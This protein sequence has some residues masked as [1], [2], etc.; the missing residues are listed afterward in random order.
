MDFHPAPLQNNQFNF[1]QPTQKEPL[2]MNQDKTREILKKVRQIEVRTNRMVDDILGGQYHSIFKGRGMDFDEVRAY[3]PGDEV[4]TID[5][6]V[7]ARSGAPFVKRFREERELTMMLMV[8]ISGSGDFGSGE[9]SKREM[10][11]EIASVLAFSALKNNDKVGLLLFT[12]EVEFYIQP[13]KGRRHILRMVRDIL[14]Y[15][16]KSRG[17]NFDKPLEFV[18]QVIR[19]RAITFLISDFCLTGDFE[20]GLERL[21]S[22]LISGRRRHDLVAISVEDP[23]DR[24]L[25]EVGLLTIEDCETGELI[26]LNTS[27]RELC[28]AF[29]NLTNERMEKLRHVFH[30]AHIDLLEI[31]TDVPYL[32]AL[33]RFFEKRE[34]RIRK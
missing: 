32:P 5:W 28:E 27:S 10:A 24:Q 15:Q 3:M 2:S 16:P 21:Q 31:T 9:Q 4:R 26:E 19:K 34:Q 23:R 8:D 29:S 1:N 33:I 12:D 6:N 30:R 13:G 14:N 22:K 7:T 11:A 17:T 18:N 20:S 25:P